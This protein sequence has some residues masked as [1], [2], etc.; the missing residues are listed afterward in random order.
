MDRAAQG[1]VKMRI[2]FSGI[3]STVIKAAKQLI[4]QG[5]E[6]ILI[7]INKEKIEEISDE[8][9]CSFLRGDAGK[10]AVLRQASPK[11][12]DFLFCLTDNDQA[13]IIT[14]LLGRS[15]G[16]HAIITCIQD[17]DLL[18][19]CEEL[20]IEDIIIPDRTMSQYIDNMVRGLH[21][22]EIST[23]LRGDARFFSFIADEDDAV[24]VSEM[25]LPDR[26]KVMYY[27]RDGA[28]FFADQETQLRPGDE[29]VIL[30]S[31]E[32]LVDLSKRW[33]AEKKEEGA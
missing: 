30:T 9:D 17:E 28:F 26:S 8:L 33:H 1:G 27:Y 12:C 10:P 24:Q 29:V 5:H 20:G 25:E 18:P 7:E 16:F 11:D 3:N 21:T 23:L 31:S 19:L 22:V 14:S 2:V 13:N 15:M 32:H 4:A 6:V